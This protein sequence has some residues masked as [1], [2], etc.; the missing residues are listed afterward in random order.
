M[1][2]SGK[3]ILIGICGGVAAYK[4]CSLIRLIIKQGG[5]VKT[6]LTKS[7]EKFITQVTLEAL[8]GEP[9]ASDLFATFPAGGIQ[10]I[11]LAKWPDC[12][13]I[14]PATA[15]ILAKSANGIADDLLSTVISAFP[16]RVLYAPAMNEVM[17]ENPA[18]RENVNT[19]EKNSNII[20]APDEGE[21]ACDT[22]GKGRLAE[23][24]IIEKEIISFLELKR[25]FSG[26]K[27]L[28]TA[29]GTEEPIDPV[30]VIGNRS[31][32]KMGFALAETAHARGAEV[33][34][35]VGSF[36]TRMPVGMKIIKIS[37]AAQMANAVKIEAGRHDALLMAA[38][39]A[40]YRPVVA[41]KKKMKKGAGE[42]ISLQL[43]R[44]EDILKNI[45]KNHPDV[46]LIGFALE[47]DDCEQ[48]ALKKLKE[49]RLDIIVLNNPLEKD[50][51]FDVD[52]NRVTLFEKGKKAK[53]FPVMSKR[54]VADR[55]LDRVAALLK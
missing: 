13:L 32:G 36:K 33:T 50:S 43:E 25:D 44:T 7:G 42:N 37:T 54:N 29:G 18:T 5:E 16:G 4:V 6:I 39:V 20:I 45:G 48:N 27:I 30:R 49:K 53:E 10:H 41:Q 8:S 9:V 14:A 22:V 23:P 40:D 28:V 17:W 46:V 24:E 47:T 19:L 55:I 1:I 26:K 35:I 51:G 52:T 15:N 21:L 3:K 38:A 11:E 31:S 34:L 12:F 2:F